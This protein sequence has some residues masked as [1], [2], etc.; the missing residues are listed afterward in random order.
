MRLM[1]REV[2]SG[3]GI[4]Y[5]VVSHDYSQANYSSSRLSLLDERDVWKSLQLWFIRTFRYRIHKRFMQAAVLAK[6]IKEVDLQDYATDPGRFEQ[7]YF[8]P[9]GWQWI[10]PTKEVT[11]YKDAVKGGMMTLGQVI[12]QTAGGDDIED[13]METRAQ[14]LEF[15]DEEKLVFD[16]SPSVYVPAES[17]GQVLIDEEG[18][19]AP[20]SV[21]AAQGLAE[22]GILASGAPI[23]SLAVPGVPGAP[24]TTAPQATVS[25]QPNPEAEDFKKKPAEVPNVDEDEEDRSRRRM[26][27]ISS[28]RGF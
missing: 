13:M 24:G 7:V 27:L 22:S 21:V 6:A 19:P 17:R 5:E 26:R 12:A 15:M 25:A 18:S 1:L 23:G 8:R 4:S 11:A 20:A 14:E 28:Q 3:L 9:R 16:T 2:S 10:D